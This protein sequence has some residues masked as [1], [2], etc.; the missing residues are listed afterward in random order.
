MCTLVCFVCKKYRI[1]KNCPSCEFLTAIF[2]ITLAYYSEVPY[3]THVFKTQK[4]CA[5]FPKGSLRISLLYEKDLWRDDVLHTVEVSTSGRQAS[6]IFTTLGS[7]G[8]GITTRDASRAATRTHVNIPVAC[9]GN[10]VW[11]RIRTP[12]LMQER[13]I[14][15]VGP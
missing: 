6:E 7:P 11:H 14:M 3:C 12:E 8:D 9:K 2:V 4:V 5:S 1:N 15:S 13:V 10:S